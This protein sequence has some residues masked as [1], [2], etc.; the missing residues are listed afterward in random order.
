VDLGEDGMGQIACLKLEW[1]GVVGRGQNL[2]TQVIFLVWSCLKGRIAGVRGVRGIPQ[3][4][5]TPVRDLSI[6]V[7][8]ERPGRVRGAL[9]GGDVK[10]KG[11]KTGLRWV[12][13][14][15]QDVFATIGK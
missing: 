1:G 9:F 2:V 7:W 3:E 4:Q 15:Q 6:G 11:K 5:Q 8:E 10:R 12:G 14:W 13:G